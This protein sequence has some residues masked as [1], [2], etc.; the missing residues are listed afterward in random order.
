MESDSF[1]TAKLGQWHLSQKPEVLN[2]ARLL[3]PSSYEE[4]LTPT[5]YRTGATS[6]ITGAGL[7]QTALGTSMT[8]SRLV[9][10]PD[11]YGDA[12]A[13]KRRSRVMPAA[14]DQGFRL[15]LLA[16]HRSNL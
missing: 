11:D 10:I 16:S 1:A 12:S 8:A 7:K 14:C 13:A 3:L 6:G 5:G 4:F 2:H 15:H 9:C